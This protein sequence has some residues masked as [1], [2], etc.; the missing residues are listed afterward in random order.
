MAIYEI[1][2]TPDNQRF[3]IDLNGSTYQLRLIWRDSAWIMDI[4]DS[5]GQRLL[6][7]LPLLPGEDLLAQHSH[8][9]FGFALHVISDDDTPPGKET[10]GVT[11]HL[12]LLT[13]PI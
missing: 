13:E 6:S 11:S 5:A 4:K 2:L 10:L 9:A 12:Y 1:P 3:S 7:G 8:L